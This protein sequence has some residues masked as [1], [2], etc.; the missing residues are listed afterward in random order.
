ME[1]SLVFLFLVINAEMKIINKKK[2]GKGKTLVI[3]Q[4]KEEAAKDL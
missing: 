2:K 4:K 1:N 3:E